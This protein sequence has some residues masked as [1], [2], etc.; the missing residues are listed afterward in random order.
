MR[1]Q[2]TIVPRPSAIATA[3]LTQSG[4]NFVELSISLLNAVT[5]FCVSGSNLTPPLPNARSASDVRYMS[6]RTL[7]TASTGTRASEP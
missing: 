7:P 4:M 2:P 5:F 1:F 3:T 6:L